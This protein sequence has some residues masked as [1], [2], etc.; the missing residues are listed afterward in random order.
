MLIFLCF[1]IHLIK[2]QKTATML[3][4]KRGMGGFLALMKN[5]SSFAIGEYFS[6]TIVLLTFISKNI[7]YLLKSLKAPAL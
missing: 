7:H 5:L 1:P 2:Y 6:G 4:P 3:R